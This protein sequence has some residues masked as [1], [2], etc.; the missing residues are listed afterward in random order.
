MLRGCVDV[1][2]DPHAATTN[3]RPVPITACAVRFAK[4]CEVMSTKR[5]PQQNRLE[6]IN[7]PQLSRQLV[8]PAY[9]AAIQRQAPR[10]RWI[11]LVIR[12]R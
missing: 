10:N 1:L 6:F 3:N 8:K 5:E 4:N 7:A 12:A 11:F 2:P 9:N